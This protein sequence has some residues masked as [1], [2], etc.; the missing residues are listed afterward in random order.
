VLLTNVRT[1]AAGLLVAVLAGGGNSAPVP[2]ERAKAEKELAALAE[3]LHGS[4]DGGPCEGTITFRA[5]RTYEW[6]GIGPGGD[7][8]SGAWSLRGDPAEPVLVMECKKSDA[9]DRRGKTTERTVVRVDGEEFE[10]K[11]ADGTAAGVFDRVKPE[12][13]ARPAREPEE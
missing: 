9:E 13:G 11:H 4:W 8:D 10:F 3:K 5:D 6:T 12:I 2:V 1:V 7:R